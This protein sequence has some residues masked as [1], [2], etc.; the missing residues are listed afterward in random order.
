MVVTIGIR[1][2]TGDH[3]S[4]FKKVVAIRLGAIPSEPIN[5]REKNYFKEYLKSR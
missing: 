3:E 1:P 2:A 5:Q 4:N